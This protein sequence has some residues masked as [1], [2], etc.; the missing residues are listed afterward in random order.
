M[1]DLQGLPALRTRRGRVGSGLLPL[2]LPLPGSDLGAGPPPAQLCPPVL[3]QVVPHLE[4]TEE[5]FPGLPPTS[6]VGFVGDLGAGRQER[7]GL[8]VVTHRSTPLPPLQTLLREVQA[9]RDR[10]CTEDEA[11]SQATAERLL[12]VYQQLRSPSLLLL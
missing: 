2:P 6:P 10:L 5:S 8:A 3:R 11:S 4:A 7:G 1:C 12:Q 9:L